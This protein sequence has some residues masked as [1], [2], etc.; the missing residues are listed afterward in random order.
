MSL[1]FYRV[2]G[3]AVFDAGIYEG[4]EAD[5]R[6][7]V[8]ATVTVLLAAAASGFGAVSWLGMS[9][10]MI[11]ILT[12]L[13]L[14][15]WIAW[16]VLIQQIGTRVLPEAETEADLGQLLRTTGFS[17]APLIFQVLEVFRPVAMP[18]FIVTILWTFMAMV[19][20][21]RHALDYRTTARAIGVC[22]LAAAVCFGLWF[23]MSL[24]LAPNVG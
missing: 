4:I 23:I 15:T 6:V 17:A 13:A 8:Q 21:V 2:I 7:N 22:G 5:Q 10:S 19:I 24:A 18:V 3:A 16:G 1:F 12:L 9:T 14:V 20:A 11:P